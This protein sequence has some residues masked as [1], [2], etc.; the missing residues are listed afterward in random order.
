MAD[1]PDQEK[2]PLII[3]PKHHI[4][5][6]LDEH[7]HY[8]VAHQGRHL[9]AGAIRTAGLWI[10]AG[11]KLIS[12]V[13]HKCVMC[14]KLRGRLENQKMSDLPAD[15]VSVDP[16]FTHTGLDIFGPWSVVTR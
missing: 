1:L 10:V 6:L 2:H 7:Y 11:K 5:K 3:P 9:T 16:P 14:K 12:N 15:R 8:Q 13:I 4:A